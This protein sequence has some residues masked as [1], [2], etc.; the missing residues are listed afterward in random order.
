VA[1]ASISSRKPCY[2]Q[3]SP[4]QPSRTSDWTSRTTLASVHG[5][6]IW[7]AFGDPWPSGPNSSCATH[8][9]AHQRRRSRRLGST[10]APLLTTVSSR[11]NVPVAKFH[12]ALLHAWNHAPV[13]HWLRHRGIEMHRIPTLYVSISAASLF[14]PAWSLVPIWW[15]QTSVCIFN[16]SSKNDPFYFRMT[17][18]QQIVIISGKQHPEEI[19]T[20]KY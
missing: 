8:R 3:P 10:V 20:R 13:V 18:N 6:L 14:T 7:A 17:I 1:E 19:D 12:G 9:F 15:Y 11:A 5:H 4:A 16:V 2:V